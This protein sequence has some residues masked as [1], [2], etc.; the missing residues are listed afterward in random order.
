[1]TK[2]QKN[3]VIPKYSQNISDLA[4]TADESVEYARSAQ[5]RHDAILESKLESMMARLKAAEQRTAERV[6][7]KNFIFGLV[8]LLCSSLLPSCKVMDA[9]H[10][11]LLWGGARGGADEYR[12][13][14]EQ[15]AEE[16]AAMAEDRA[17]EKSKKPCQWSLDPANG[18]KVAKKGGS[19]ND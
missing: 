9:A 3:K 17:F 15:T 13:C 14:Y 11:P 7:P 12:Y 6:V 8:I 2:V 16:K 1:M 4:K 5:E 18:L 10:S 19:N